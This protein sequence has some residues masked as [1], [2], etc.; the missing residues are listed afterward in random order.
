MNKV[1]LSETV[2]SER[3]YLLFYGKEIANRMKKQ[4][5]R[6]PGALCTYLHIYV[7]KII[8]LLDI[9]AHYTA[10][11]PEADLKETSLT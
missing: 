2:A 4:R 7:I 1:Y 10:V 6:N 9:P 5:A 8:P 11:Q 3:Q